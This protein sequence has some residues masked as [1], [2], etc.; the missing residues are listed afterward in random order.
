MWGYIT[1]VISQIEK[2]EYRK[3]PAYYTGLSKLC[4]LVSQILLCSLGFPGARTAVC[5][6]GHYIVLGRP[7]LQKSIYL[8]GSDGACQARGSELETNLVYRA[9]SR[10]ARAILET[11]SQNKPKVL[12]YLIPIKDEGN[13]LEKDKV[14]G[15]KE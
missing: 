14:Q 13:C 5:M 9:S 7:S 11:L 15:F 4:F 6:I 1:K 2:L 8:P 10:T 3:A 12:I